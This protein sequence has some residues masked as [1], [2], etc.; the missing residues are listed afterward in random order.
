MNFRRVCALIVVALTGLLPAH[1][2]DHPEDPIQPGDYLLGQAGDSWRPAGPGCT[3]GFVFD[4]LSQ[5]GNRA[6]I[7]TA[8]HCVGALGS[9]ARLASGERFGKVA[10][11]GEPGIPSWE[12]ALIEVD[13]AKAKRVDPALKGHPSLPTAAG[14][15]ATV[16]PGDVVRLSGAGALV[17]YR[18]V[19]GAATDPV[20]DPSEEQ[21]IGSVVAMDANRLTIAGPTLTGVGLPAVGTPST[22]VAT[23]DAGGPVVHLGSGAALGLVGPRYPSEPTTTCCSTGPTVERIVALAAADGLAIVLRVVA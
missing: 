9:G 23:G 5:S 8:A 12:V 3:L 7:A 6:F 21:R 2:T 1:A 10:F 14:T 11:I 19:T 16:E 4:G 17:D 15:A 13:P 18:P 20:D 22:L